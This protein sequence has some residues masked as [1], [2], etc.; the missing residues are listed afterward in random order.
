MA[1]RLI[2]KL[3]HLGARL[4]GPLLLVALILS[5]LS[6]AT[7][8]VFY[9]GA[10]AELP[11]QQAPAI[12]NFFLLASALVFVVVLALTIAASV[13]VTRY[14]V[15]PLIALS[16]GAAILGRGHLDYRVEV[17][18][19]GEIGELAAELNTMAASL[20]RAQTETQAHLREISSL[21]EAGRAI[22][23]LDLQRVLDTL[24]KEAARA[25]EAQ[26]CAIYVLNESSLTME[27]RSIWDRSGGDWTPP[28]ALIGEG[29]VGWVA[30]NA[31]ALRVEDVHADSRF[32]VS[33]AACPYRSLMALPLL[34]SGRLV[35]ALQ[36]AEKSGKGGGFTPSDERLLLAFADQVALAIENAKL[37][38][39]EHRRAR[40]LAL[41][42][43]ISHTI[44]ASLDLETTL[45]AI[46]ALV[47]DLLP[48]SAAEICLWDVEK[49]LIYTR[50]WGG[51]PIYRRLA[52][53]VYG[54]D[55][56]YTGWISRHHKPLLIPDVR[57]FDE[58]KPK[59]DLV[60][61]SLCSYVG[62]PL[63]AGEV[64]IGTL[65]L[66]SSDVNVYNAQDLETLQTVANQAAVAIDNAR[67]Y[68]EA[69]RTAREK[70]ILYEATAALS[71][72][73][74]VNDLL[75]GLVQR[76]ALALNADECTI[77]EWDEASGVVRAVAEHYPAG[78]P[79]Q[80]EG[81]SGRPLSGL[82]VPYVV[83]DF[84]KTVDV[85]HNRQPQTIVAS[86]LHA[87]PVEVALMKQLGWKSLLMLPLVTRDAVVGLV[88]IYCAAERQFTGDEIRL[89]QALTSQAAVALNN[90]RIFSLTDERLRKRVEELS[91]LQQVSQELNSTLD[92]DRILRLVL[93]EVVRATGADFANVS[94]YD[95]GE[96]R[97]LAH[98]GFGFTDE[99]MARLEGVFYSG[100]GLTGRVLHTGQPV[101][102]SDVSQE[103]DYMM[104]SHKTRSEAVV[105]IIYAGDVAGVINLESQQLDA[106]NE[107]QLRYLEALS[108]QAA[109]AIRNTIAYEEQQRQRELLRQRAD[110]LARLS[111]IGHAFRSDQPLEAV[112]E[113][114]VYAVQETL[115]FDTVLISVVDDDPPVLHRVAG[116]GIPIAEME[117][118]KATPQSLQMVMSLMQDRFRLGLQSYYISHI[119]KGMW[120]GNL[121]V[122]YAQPE[123]QVAGDEKSWSADDLCFTPL[124]DSAQQLIGVLS[125]DG[126][127][128]GRIPAPQTMES[129][130]LF[131]NQAAM[132]VEN[133]RLFRSEQQRRRL[134]DTLREVAA[135]V[136]ST[137]DVDR[138]IE[139]ILDQLQHVV[140]YDS[141]TV[142][143]LRG[144]RLVVTGGRGWESLKD[145]LGLTFSLADNNPNAVVA[146]LRAP[147]IV[148][149]TR[150][151][152][153]AFREAPHDHI[154]SWLGVPLLFGDNLLG[155]IALDSVQ[156]DHYTQ[157]HAQVALT[158]ASQAAMALQN[159]QLFG[160]VRQYADRLSVLN[161]VGVQITSIL[162]VEKLVARVSQLVED[163][164]GYWANISLVEESSVDWANLPAQTP[165]VAR[166]DAAI[167]MRETTPTGGSEISIPLKVQDRVLGVFEV[168]S[169]T[170]GAFAHNE[171][172]VLQSL[173][174]QT[175]VAI[176]NAQLFER[177]SR[178]G[179]ELE[180]RVQERTEALANTLKDLTLERDR[181]E[182]L[183]SITRELSASL[184]LDRVLNEALSLIN[185]AVGVAHGAIMLLDPGTGNLIYRTA[186]G[187]PRGLQR[188]GAV[189]PYRR[190]VGL[191]GWVLETREAV[192]VPDVTQDPHWVPVDRE[193]D[194]PRRAALAVPL[195][196]GEDVLGVL[197]L[198]HPQVDYF[199]PDHLKLV[200]AAAIQVATAINNAE[201][202][203]LITDQAERLGAMLRT[204]RAESA[205]HQAIVEGIADGVL[206][207]DSEYHVVLMNPAASRI[208][209][210]N[211]SMVE[212]QHVRQI[213][214][215]AET[216]T[217]Q[218]VAQQLYSRLMGS[219]ERF[220]TRDY[221]QNQKPSGL[222][223]R[224]Q[225][226]DKTIV[227]S[228]SPLPLGGSSL[229]SLVTVLRDISREA[230]MERMKNEFIST[231]SH[232]LRTP[233]TSIKGYTDLLIGEKVG[234]LSDQQRRFVH[235]IKTNADRLTALVNDFLDISRM[236]TGRVKLKMENLDVIALVHTVV[237]NFR[238]QMVEKE[239]ELVVD[240]PARLPLV[241]GDE[242][243]V[244][245]ILENLTSNAWKYTPAGG[246]VTVR[247]GVT[248][249]FVQIDVSDTGIGI[250]E[251]DQE[252]IFDRFYRTEQ[253]EVRAVD[254][255][256]LGLSI[257][258]MLIGLLG[259]DIWVESRENQGT[260]FSFTLP[261]VP[262]TASE[263]IGAKTV[264]SKILVVDDDEDITQLLRHHLEA[265]GYRVLAA[266]HEE[267]VL[268]LARREQPDLITLDILLDGVDGFDVLA[269]LKQDSAT[270]EIPVIIVS[271]VPDAETRG[272][273]LGA[274][275]YISKP[276]EERQVLDQIRTVLTS[277]GVGGNGRLNRVLVV[278]D[279]RHIVDWLKEALTNNGFTV[280]GA[281]NGHEALALA[282]EDSPDLILLDL[283]MPDM[284]GYEVIRGL[285]RQQATRAIPVI[286]ITGY[287]LDNDRDKVEILGMGVANTLIKPFSV[288]AL[289]KE[290]KR[291]GQKLPA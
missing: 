90:A 245:Q 166:Y 173:A 252:H 201:L 159:A 190:G 287:A 46:L 225:T 198:F 49:S 257:V 267:D 157:E 160:Q 5:A 3:G 288:E 255:T 260:T 280:R 92:Q 30:Q 146:S 154:R 207:L 169:D 258:K 263:P 57:T 250:A 36:V 236:E 271:I 194:P 231:V 266:Q 69:Q 204:Q 35:G 182:T 25:A 123:R 178:M 259:G 215:R 270:A 219:V 233:M 61:L 273:A 158:F 98:V 67:L 86:D 276:F 242:D 132:A 18:A 16:E 150:A 63:M 137:L 4:W 200:N 141:A 73:L 15:R 99:E 209:G 221:V 119:Y 111:E 24:A 142:Q 192:I 138:V 20:Q 278:D 1:S 74:S 202:Y 188:E 28:P 48:Y 87:D 289:V 114:I 64:F 7:L 17:D 112:L 34:V 27:P 241:R 175:A 29:V 91:G 135:V 216:V 147:Y 283:K 128:D 55:E 72:T 206:V 268:Q 238:G 117:R 2:R 81:E 227:V 22:T 193:P 124:Y 246:K 65:E 261:I 6:V 95:R 168:R 125:V 170:P 269:K 174:G 161:E 45:D 51:D 26:A 177:V 121:D 23:S 11:T 53:D 197:L 162:N 286:V 131:A 134:A 32:A 291:V 167:A 38:G 196:A 97:L 172:L 54:P 187:R 77:S 19:R 56:G 179:Q 58:I 120:Q 93:R 184:D 21:V 37:F 189:T 205:K 50:G 88:E 223:F 165:G 31:Q 85:L 243:R 181:V 176:A 39:E 122:Q 253:A 210:I 244:I 237:D 42:N 251:K 115:S 240:L 40:E 118:L 101:L 43:R 126:P 279:D 214:G 9:R 136:S 247:A 265:E 143:V 110:Q 62:V 139:A 222:E 249:D 94:L 71:S 14:V 213:L 84:P 156:V 277:A 275:G 44:T 185:R 66:V 78:R 106:F 10:A 232:E 60:N 79:P 230:E 80:G 152:Y 191:A 145:I 186:L 199:T 13:L 212:G 171:T 100:E 229:P 256:G 83:A 208:L 133:A 127:R 109:V 163:I 108:N 234:V 272:L 262:Q 226:E 282:R 104:A 224:V 41:V 70:S 149:D 217:D 264:E 274:A 239:L 290:I 281:Y 248:D 144:D 211:A 89:A 12:A 148:P 76:M 113:D 103:P 254:G 105:P 151:A 284:D 155:I 102:I 52:T 140:P 220:N 59:V 183:Y 180:Q 75:D 195:T 116:A 107:A 130:E 129:M 228:V 218:L 47:R 203:R 68:D 96:K 82:G 153:P 8:Y 235:V 164:F 285:R 33:E